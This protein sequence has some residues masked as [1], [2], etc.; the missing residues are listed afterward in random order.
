MREAVV[1]AREDT[2]GDKRLVAYYTAA[3][4]EHGFRRGALRSHLSAALPEYMVPAAYIRLDT[5]PLT[6]NGKLDRK[7]LPAPDTGAYA[8]HGYEPPQ[9]EIETALAQIWAE[10]LKLDRIGRHDNFF[11]LGGHSLLAAQMLTRIET[12]L[13]SQLSMRSFLESP[14]IEGMTHTLKASQ[15][16]N[17]YVPL[18]AIRKSG[19]TSPLFCFHPGVGLG[20]SYSRLITVID[21]WVPIY[22]L[23]ARGLDQKDS[24]ATS[25][26][27]MIEDYL[28]QIRIVQPQGPYHLLGWSFGGLV[29][30]EAAARLRQ[31]GD[32]IRALIL[33][34]AFPSL[35]ESADS[36]LNKSTLDKT[37]IEELN[38]DASDK[39][40]ASAPINND[41]TRLKLLLH[42][43]PI[44]AQM[45]DLQ[46]ERIVSVIE[47]NARLSSG[48]TP[49]QFDGDMVLVIAT[50]RDNIRSP[51]LWRQYLSGEIHTHYLHC[52]H[53]DMTK[54]G[55]ISSLG[56]IINRYLESAMS[57]S[58]RTLLADQ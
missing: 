27:E 4:E 38:G 32:A 58:S 49:S 48:Y 14:T 46:L 12:L 21:P 28:E 22:A 56:V 25:L 50:L 24:V 45:D 20:W 8:T 7:A 51:D 13:Q 3:F 39:L 40:Q 16:L 5:L 18:L 44:F 57:P 31:E 6:P 23:Q 17:A 41:R 53:E 54:P 26:S 1:I 42:E 37:L 55:H 15:H 9:G 52:S 11:S 10:V 19:H 36:R 47:N 43:D 33:L 29:A 30:Y 2:P 34:D 35:K